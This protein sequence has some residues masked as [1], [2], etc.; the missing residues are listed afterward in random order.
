M[1]LKALF[2]S[3]SHNLNILEFKCEVYKFVKHQRPFGESIMKCSSSIF[4]SHYNVWRHAL[5]PNTS[6]ARWLV[7]FI[8]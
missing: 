4:H 7:T 1:V 5:T 6:G 3:L 2:S 8:N